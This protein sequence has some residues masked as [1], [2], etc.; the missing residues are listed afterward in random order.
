VGG[1]DVGVVRYA[2]DGSHSL[3]FSKRWLTDNKVTDIAF[4][5]QG[6]AWIATS[7]GVSAIKRVMMT[8]ADKEKNFYSQLMKKHMSYPWTCGILKLDKNERCKQNLFKTNNFI[9]IG[10]SF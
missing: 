7:N 9:W 1:T 5:K 3:R 2:R 10:F 4:D 6:T 8:M